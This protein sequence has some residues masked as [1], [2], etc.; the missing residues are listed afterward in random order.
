M[1]D[2]LKYSDDARAVLGAWFGFGGKT[3]LE[4]MLRENKPAPRTQAALD[5]LVAAGALSV[6]PFNQFGGLVY[7]PLIDTLPYFSWLGENATN[8]ALKFQLMVPV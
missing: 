2:D 4:L 5:E 7:R 8:P 3:K 6:E 1:S